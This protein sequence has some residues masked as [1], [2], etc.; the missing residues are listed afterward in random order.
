MIGISFLSFD[1]LIIRLTFADQKKII[2]GQKSQKTY[3]IGAYVAG[4][5]MNMEK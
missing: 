5:G 3:F 1:T 4:M 2:M